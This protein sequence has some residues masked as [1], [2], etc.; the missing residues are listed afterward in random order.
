[1]ENREFRLFGAAFEQEHEFRNEFT[2]L[3]QSNFKNVYPEIFLQKTSRS[4]RARLLGSGFKTKIRRINTFDE[5][6]YIA[7]AS[8]ISKQ[9]IESRYSSGAYRKI[10]LFCKKL[11]GRFAINK[12]AIDKDAELILSSNL[13]DPKW[14]SEN[15]NI[16]GNPMQLAEHYLLHGYCSLYDPSPAFSTKA[17]LAAYFDV[18]LTPINPLIHYLIF[19]MSEKRKITINS[20]DNKHENL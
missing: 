15:Y 8:T 5:S 6:S 9:T 12:S 18:A 3:T 11:L 10:K 19:G 17:Y 4:R 1:M 16:E 2:E 14:Y 13:F 7:V 20:L